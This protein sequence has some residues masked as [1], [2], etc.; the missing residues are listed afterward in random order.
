MLGECRANKSLEGLESIILRGLENL[1]A[2]CNR[3]SVVIVTIFTNLFP[4]LSYETK[5]KDN[6]VDK[7]LF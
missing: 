4:R 6:T 5:L 7:N 1:Q 3:D 2:Y